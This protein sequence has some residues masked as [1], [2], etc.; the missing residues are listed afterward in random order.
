MSNLH[1]TKNWPL[2]KGAFPTPSPPQMRHRKAQSH[3]RLFYR[4]LLSTEF[5]FT[6]HCSIYNIHDAHKNQTKT[7][8][9]CI[10]FIQKIELSVYSLKFRLMHLFSIFLQFFSW[11]LKN[12]TLVSVEQ[13]VFIPD[14]PLNCVAEYTTYVLPQTGAPI[15]VAA[16]L[17][18]S[19]L[20]FLYCLFCGIGAHYINWL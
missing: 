18:F 2:L 17:N 4:S 6:N 11:I 1:I 20:L 13:S 5:P 12:A 7:S 9:C 3:F 15:G 8:S 14:I 19:C 10:H 16:T